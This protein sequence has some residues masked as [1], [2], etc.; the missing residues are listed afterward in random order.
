MRWRWRGLLKEAEELTLKRGGEGRGMSRSKG[1]EEG[2][3]PG[4]ALCET[5]RGD[6]AGG[7]EDGVGDAVRAGRWGQ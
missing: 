1:L 3:E 5:V 6:G 2:E 7:G 4:A